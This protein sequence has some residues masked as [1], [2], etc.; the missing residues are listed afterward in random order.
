MC[1]NPNN[2]AAYLLKSC[3]CLLFGVAVHL[4]AVK[5]II[6]VCV[7]LYVS[8]NLLQRSIFHQQDPTKQKDL[9][10]PEDNV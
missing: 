8:A 4:Q 5:L 7:I 6:Q 9:F 2:S 10:S 3:L 1:P